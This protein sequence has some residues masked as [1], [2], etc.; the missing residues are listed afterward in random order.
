MKHNMQELR[1][2]EIFKNNSWV[3]ISFKEIK[4]KDRFRLYEPTG[5]IVMDNNGITEFIA[6][7]D[8]FLGPGTGV[9]TIDIADPCMQKKI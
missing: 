1:K 2:T 9:H 6:Q 8:A 7:S 5:E 3:T 4:N